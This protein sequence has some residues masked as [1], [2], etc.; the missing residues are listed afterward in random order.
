[1]VLIEDEVLQSARISEQDLR[2]ELA[3]LLYQQQR[4][5]FGQARRLAGLA[6]ATF[7]Q[8]LFAR[9]IPRFTS[10]ALADDLDTLDYL[11]SQ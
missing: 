5:S 9:G 4:L 8:I 7:E 3:V 10:D 11:K 2:V 6:Y 1:M